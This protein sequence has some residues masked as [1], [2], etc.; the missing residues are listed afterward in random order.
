MHPFMLHEVL[1]EDRRRDLLATAA[2][3]R[4]RRRKRTLHGRHH[5]A[6][7]AWFR[8]HLDRIRATPVVA[9]AECGER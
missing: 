3:S 8:L 6:V 9:S 1:V 2:T 7:V 5:A 4:T